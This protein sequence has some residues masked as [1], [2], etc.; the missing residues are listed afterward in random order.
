MYH[1]IAGQVKCRCDLRLSRG[2]RI[3]LT[4]HNIIAIIP[5]FDPRISMNTIINAV[6]ARLITSGHTAVGSIYDGSHLQSG[7]ISL[8]EIEICG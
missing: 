2:L 3:S 8:P 4:L 7:D 5:Q 6:M 1:I